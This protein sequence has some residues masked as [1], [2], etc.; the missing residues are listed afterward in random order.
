MIRRKPPDVSGAGL[1]LRGPPLSPGVVRG[2]GT[3]S[4]DSLPRPPPI[5]RWCP[6]RWSD[7]VSPS[8]QSINPP[9]P[10]LTQLGPPRPSGRYWMGNG[11]ICKVGR[12]ARLGPLPARSDPCRARPARFAGPGL[13]LPGRSAQIS[14]GR[15]AWR[16]RRGENRPGK[17]S[18][19]GPSAAHRPARSLTAG[20]GQKGLPGPFCARR[21][22][23][24]R[25][26]LAKAR[27][28][29]RERPLL[30]RPGPA[31]APA[32]PATGPARA[33]PTYVRGPSYIRR[34]PSKCA[35][36]Q[37]ARIL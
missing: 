18:Y 33:R 5:S 24:E 25:T 6:S 21:A 8:H 13:P 17:P 10:A 29:A 35:I 28:A 20:P 31:G 23:E 12:R 34:L 26:G 22:G 32:G 14:T 19:P 3:T 1:L 7:C 11:S 2:V 37:A 36:V 27:S 16:A 4:R 9:G 30:T 15:G